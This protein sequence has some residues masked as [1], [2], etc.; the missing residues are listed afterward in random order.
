MRVQGTVRLHIAMLRVQV[1]ALLHVTML[2]V[3]VAALV[4]IAM[5]RFQ[6]LALL[7]IAILRV[8]DI[9]LLGG[10]S[11]YRVIYVSRLWVHDPLMCPY[12]S[13]IYVSC[14]FRANMR[15]RRCCIPCLLPYIAHL[16]RSSS[17][18]VA[19]PGVFL[20]GV[21]PPS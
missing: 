15:N 11:P 17:C 4:H 21:L 13:R 7:H 10:Y 18:I 16:T 20:V 19:L 3:H 14:R 1:P 12:A 9:S 6:V 8:Q 2:R 5:L